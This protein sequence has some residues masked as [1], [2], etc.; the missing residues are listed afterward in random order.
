[1]TEAN[2]QQPPCQTDYVCWAQ[3]LA[4]LHAQ[5]PSTLTAFVIDDFTENFGTFTPAY[6][7]QVHSAA[8][9]LPFYPI[10]YYSASWNLLE[11]FRYLIDD[12]QGLIDELIYPFRNEKASG[13]TYDPTTLQMSSLRCAGS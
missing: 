7:A 3:K 4:E 1:P 12:Y 2:G 6:L 13:D 9:G 5:Y 8:S 11:A 10:S